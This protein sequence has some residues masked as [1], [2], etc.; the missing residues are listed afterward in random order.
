MLENRRS[1]SRHRRAAVG[2][3]VALSLVAVLAACGG[4]G[5]KG[6]GAADTTGAVAPAGAAPA[7]TT[8]TAA[9]GGMGAQVFA[10]C[11]TCHQANGAGMA[12]VYPPLAG[13]ELLNGNPAI[14]I[15]IVLN[16]LQGPVTVKGQ[17]YNSV[18]PGWGAQFSDAQIAAVLT[19][20][21]SSFG[22][23]SSPVTEQQ[24]A[25][26]RKATSSRTTAWTAAELE[27]VQ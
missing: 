23:S 11:A 4:G 25:A 16:G 27:E 2:G 15:R 14:P 21:R 10:T 24:V 26:V 7:G 22:N 12:N 20:E 3:T 19:Y 6:A 5:E 17:Q 13:S 8:T 9:A 1:S 18:M